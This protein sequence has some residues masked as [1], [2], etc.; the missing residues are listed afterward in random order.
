MESILTAVTCHKSTATL[1]PAACIGTPGPTA[2]DHHGPA[3]PGGGERA[4][5]R[6]VAGRP[7]Y[8]FGGHYVDV[9]GVRHNPEFGIWGA[10]AAD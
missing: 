3:P 2:A 10:T 4:G 5:C 1:L 7:E 6:A 8:Q 9:V